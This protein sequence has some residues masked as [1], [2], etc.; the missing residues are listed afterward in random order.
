MPTAAELRPTRLPPVHK[1]AVRVEA[2]ALEGETL[3]EWILRASGVE[4]LGTMPTDVAR[5]IV[6]IDAL[7]FTLTSREKRS[8]FAYG[9]WAEGGG[10]A[11]I[12]RYMRLRLNVDIDS[13]I[14]AVIDDAKL[15]IKDAKLLAQPVEKRGLGSRNEDVVELGTLLRSI[16]PPAFRDN[17]DR[18]RMKATAKEIVR[19]QRDGMCYADIEAMRAEISAKTR[20]K[21]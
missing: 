1:L 9:L 17:Q 18:E 12:R 21:H 11:N 2:P 19:L 20:L 13:L 3:E 14:D 5:Q 10:F 7:D 15:T 4:N 8:L 16:E 6:V